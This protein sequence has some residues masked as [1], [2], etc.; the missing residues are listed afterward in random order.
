MALEVYAHAT[1]R[2][3]RDAAEELAIG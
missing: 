3:Q 1:R 2:M